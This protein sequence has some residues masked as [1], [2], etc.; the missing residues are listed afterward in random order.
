MTAQGLPTARALID[1]LKYGLQDMFASSLM[2]Q[3]TENE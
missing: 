2:L 1:C 3:A